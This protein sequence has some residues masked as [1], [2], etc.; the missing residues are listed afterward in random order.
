MVRVRG[1][2][3]CPR[4]TMPPAVDVSD[5]T[6]HSIFSHS[7]VAILET[8]VFFRRFES[9]T[10][11]VLNNLVSLAVP[12]GASR[13][14]GMRSRARARGQCSKYVITVLVGLAIVIAYVAARKLQAMMKTTFVGKLSDLNATSAVL[15]TFEGCPPDSRC[16][17]NEF[18]VGCICNGDIRLHVLGS[19]ID[20]EGRGLPCVVG[21]HYI[22]TKVTYAAPVVGPSHYIATAL[23]PNSGNTLRPK[24]CNGTWGSWFSAEKVSCYVDW[25]VFKEVQGTASVGVIWRKL[26]GSWRGEPAYELKVSVHKWAQVNPTIVMTYVSFDR[27]FS[28][29]GYSRVWWNWCQTDHQSGVALGVVCTGTSLSILG[30]SPSLTL[31][32]R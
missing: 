1:P 17:M 7:L 16:E 28:E 3:R 13:K 31:W 25:S 2:S 19:D 10:M 11:K 9:H 20:H 32:M 5:Q 29:Y 14:L 26:T 22:S 6:S 21:C 4:Q 15:A 12:A 8:R 27:S 23:P 24:L 30:A 18:R